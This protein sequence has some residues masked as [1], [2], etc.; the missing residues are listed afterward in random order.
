[1]SDVLAAST[2]TLFAHGA[3][4]T[5][6]NVNAGSLTRAVPVEVK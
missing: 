2:G 6:V 1:V 3:G 4:T 5:S